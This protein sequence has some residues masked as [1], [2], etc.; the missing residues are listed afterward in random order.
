MA[1]NS[2]AFTLFCFSLE[3]NNTYGKSVYDIYVFNSFL[4]PS[5]KTYSA[6]I[7]KQVILETCSKIPLDLMSIIAV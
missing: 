4:I 6:P 7:N 1:N 5:F 3:N 2:N